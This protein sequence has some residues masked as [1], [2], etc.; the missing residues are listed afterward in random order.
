[1][2]KLWSL[3]MLLLAVSLVS[4]SMFGNDGDDD[5]KD[6]PFTIIGCWVR[7]SAFFADTIVYEFAS[8][9][10][11][12]LYQ[13]YAMT[14]V[15]ISDGWSLSGDSLTLTHSPS[16]SQITVASANE[17]SWDGVTYY[18][19]GFEPD[20]NG[21]A[22]V[23]GGPA[24]S[25]TLGTAYEGE[26]TEENDIGAFSVAVEDGAS[27]KIS[28]DDSYEGSGSYTAD[29]KVSAYKADKET[30]YFAGAD[31]GYTSPKTVTADGTT[32]YIITRPIALGLSGTYSLKVTKVTP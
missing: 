22:A 5:D 17:F 26:F 20:G 12:T 16:S 30:V 4:C 23:L 25:L 24:T 29:I 14:T 8:D 32:I 6:A 21:A 15:A 13:N 7:E 11:F 10:T 27:Y 1:M 3:F 18:R 19:K 9:G 2:K 28:W 31:N